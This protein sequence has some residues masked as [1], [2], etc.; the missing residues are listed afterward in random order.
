MSSSVNF[1]SENI[2][3]PSEIDRD[4][5]DNFNENSQM[6]PNIDESFESEPEAAITPLP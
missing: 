3:N 4:M 6:I 2:I 1:E 5:N